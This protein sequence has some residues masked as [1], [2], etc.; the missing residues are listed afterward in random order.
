M[1]S[2]ELMTFL[3]TQGHVAKSHMAAVPDS[4]ANILR[5]RRKPKTPAKKKATKSASVA[6]KS[7][8]KTSTD[9]RGG[10]TKTGKDEKKSTRTA[11]S[12]TAPDR[13]RQVARG[14]DRGRESR[15]GEKDPNKKD[16]AAKPRDGAKPVRR[17]KVRYFPQD[18]YLMQ[19]QVR[20]LPGG[21][22]RPRGR[23]GDRR[24]R[25]A[26]PSI[27]A[28]LPEKIAV[29]TPVTLKDLSGALG[30]KA[31]LLV[32]KLF[33][34]GKPVT[35]NQYLDEQ[36]IL[37]L[38][39]DLGT[40]ITVRSKEEKLAEAVEDLEKYESAGDK[41]VS[42]APVVTFLGHVD[43]G[44]T[45]LLDKIRETN[46]TGS[47]E[48]GITQHIGA[49]RVDRGDI[50][51]TF[52]DTPGH[53]AFTEMRAR[54]ADIT[55][56]AVLVVAADDG[57][58]PQTEEAINHARAAKVPIL[59]ALNKI[60][61][62]NADPQRAKEALSALGLMPVEWNGTT[63]F[64]EVSAITGQGI[65]ALLETLTLEAEILE[66]KADP[67][68]PAIGVVLEAEATTQRG[69]IAT[70]LI[71]DGTLRLGDYVL[72]GSSHGRVRN[73]ILNGTEPLEE[74]KPSM[75][76]QVIG[77]NQVPDTGDKLYVFENDKRA[78]QVAGERET[79]QRESERAQRQQVN[80]ENLFE[81]LNAEEV[82]ELRLIIKA[83]VRG[84][85]EALTKSLEQL[86]TGEVKIVILHTGVG[87]ISQE[88]I[89]LASASQAVVIGFHVTTDDR[90]RLLAEEKQVDVRH[91]RVIYETIEDVRAALESRLA[92]EVV[93]EV[94]GRSEIRQVYRASKVGN[95]AGCYVT[96]GFVLRSD[97]VRLIR[98]GTVLYSGEIGSLRHFKDDVREVKEGH[99]CGLKIANYEDIKEGDS[100]EAFTVTEKKRNL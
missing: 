4:V 53:K 70:V 62:A 71:Q 9:G 24:G 2:K 20:S 60:D 46:V 81:H 72:C 26:A 56:I 73:L 50:H 3:R 34:K 44:K 77:L 86:S 55:D 28:K 95:I 58:K 68:R 45:S 59:V 99:E 97:K 94:H 82:Q 88:D 27:P 65:D 19:S 49:Y 11:S 63:E 93:E 84:S 8:T 79:K 87:G 61:K 52:I 5:D 30:I 90:A 98:D 39:V 64:V 40:E 85:V 32:K 13:G 76:V 80:L 100:I 92:P 75:P 96:S 67:S 54:G 12:K 47:E 15:P 7:T 17:G 83:D 43:H 78:R 29:V 38:G 31:G 10:A 23:G 6:A 42:R 22:R 89:H 57:P 74:A 91:Y 18:D 14:P 41:I 33:D 69:V 1:S 37:E 36:T 35:V 16:S 48:G 66:L 21:R 51:I 25:A